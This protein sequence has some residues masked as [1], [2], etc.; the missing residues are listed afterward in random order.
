LTPQPPQ[1]FASLAPVA[2][3]QPFAATPSQSPNPAAQPPTTQLLDAHAFTVTLGSAHDVVQLPQCCSLTVVLTQ[4]PE[5]FV[6]PAAQ[7]AVHALDEQTWPPLH[8][9]LH[10]PQ[11][12]T[13]AAVFV[14]QPLVGLPSQSANPSWHAPSAHAPAVHVAA[15]FA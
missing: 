9:L 5:Q 11:F 7:L 8:A 14:S 6:C 3:S 1:L 15:A 2:V 10:A 4:L 13:S 12:A